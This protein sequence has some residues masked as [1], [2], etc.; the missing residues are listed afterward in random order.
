[1]ELAAIRTA[2]GKVS[3][4]GSELRIQLLDGRIAVL[5]DDTT[6]GLQFALPRYA[7]YHKAMHSH[8]VHRVHYEGA[9]AYL[10]LDDSTG[11][12]TIVFAE[13]IVSPDG[14][15]FVLTS[16]TGAAGY[17]PSY[18]Q[19][20]RMVGRKPEKEFSYDTYDE[21]WE[22]SDAVWRDSVTIDFIKNSG[23]DPSKPYIETP[24]RLTR[25][26]TTW[27]ISQSPP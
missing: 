20:W 22:A 10:V 16:M 6:P 9:G 12:T 23:N 7:G 13:P 5:K 24:G 19:V 25:I 15:R 1:M 2:E 4:A 27:V 21:P 14:R 8:V 18:I 3:R 11:D 17:D 26:G